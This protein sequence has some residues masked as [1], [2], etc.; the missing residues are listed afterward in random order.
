MFVFFAFGLFGENY[1]KMLGLEAMVHATV[2]GIPSPGAVGASEGVFVSIFIG[3]FTEKL[4]N[5]AMLLN[6]G[7]GFYLFVA[8]SG[9][10]VCINLFKAKKEMK[11]EGITEEQELAEIEEEIEEEYKKE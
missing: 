2:S 3:V 8:I 11:K 4:I 9:I 7:I 6:R 5:G 10:I 1:I